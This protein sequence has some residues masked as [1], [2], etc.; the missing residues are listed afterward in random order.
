MNQKSCSDPVIK[1][2]LEPF[3]SRIHWDVLCLFTDT[4]MSVALRYAKLNKKKGV[5]GAETAVMN[6]GLWVVEITP[7]EESSSGEFPAGIEER[8]QVSY[9]HSGGDDN[10]QIREESFRPE[11]T[12]PVSFQTGGWTKPDI[13]DN[14]ILGSFSAFF[15]TE[16]RLSTFFVPFFCQGGFVWCWGL[17]NSPYVDIILVA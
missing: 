2:R 6:P 9:F 1:I 12:Q 16:C 10:L 14:P 7:L 4:E 13:V 5:Y 3:I 15:T 17:Y 11:H 8:F